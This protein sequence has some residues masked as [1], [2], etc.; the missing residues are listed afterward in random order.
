[1]TQFEAVLE[2]KAKAAEVGI[3]IKEI[4]FLNVHAFETEASRYTQVEE[5]L[6]IKVSQ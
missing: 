5:I 2:L 1:M 6:G 3:I 4:S